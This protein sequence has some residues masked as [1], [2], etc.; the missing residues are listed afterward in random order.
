MGG[1]MRTARMY[2]PTLR[3]PADPAPSCAAQRR[4][5]RRWPGVRPRAHSQ[6]VMAAARAMAHRPET[7]VVAIGA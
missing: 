3:A 1:P 5:S 6:A 2:Q 7:T 4:P